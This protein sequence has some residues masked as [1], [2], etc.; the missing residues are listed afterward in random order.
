M[1]SAIHP[2]STDTNFPAMKRRAFAR[3][4]IGGA[5]ALA[6]SACGGGGGDGDSSDDASEPLRA[7][8]DKLTP[9]LTQPEVLA[10]VNFAPKENFE[11]TI[12]W[13][14]GAETLHVSFEI[15]QGDTVATASSAIWSG[16]GGRREQ[17][18][19]R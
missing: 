13:Q 3:L 17:G 12:I 19:I 9:G 4:A 8:Y 11:G 6:L 7:V 5:A 14:K 2:L 15:L 1:H 18:T 10:M 16:S